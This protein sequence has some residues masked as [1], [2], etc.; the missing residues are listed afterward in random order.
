[1]NSKG[2]DSKRQ[3]QFPI[4][5]TSTDIYFLFQTVIFEEIRSFNPNFIMVSYN[6]YLNI[7]EDHW[8]EIV[9]NLTIIA[10]HKI[11]MYVDFIDRL[12]GKKTA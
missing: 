4:L 9:K 2:R 7:N 1:M 8:N 5:Q 10:D 11:C 12:G 6:G 3:R